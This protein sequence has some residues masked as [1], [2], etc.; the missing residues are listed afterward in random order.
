[1]LCQYLECQMIRSENNRHK[2]K[3]PNLASRI[4]YKG[5]EKDILGNL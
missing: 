4:F 1:M 2:W 3:N 5:Y